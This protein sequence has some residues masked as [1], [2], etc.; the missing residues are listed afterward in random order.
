MT[1]RELFLPANNNLSYFLSLKKPRKRRRK[2]SCLLAQNNGTLRS[3]IQNR[4][5]RNTVKDINI[6]TRKIH[7]IHHSSVIGPLKKS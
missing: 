3:R 1:R 7:Q 5:R 2:K 4:S 6:T